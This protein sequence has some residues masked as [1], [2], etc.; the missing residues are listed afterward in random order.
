[1]ANI[2]RILL[3][4]DEEPLACYLTAFYEINIDKAMIQNAIIRNNYQWLNYLWVFEKNKIISV[5][6]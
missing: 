6:G 2:I 3:Y 1:M 5:V 4:M